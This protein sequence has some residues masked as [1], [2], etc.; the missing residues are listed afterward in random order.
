M[1]F[2]FN[3]VL[4][5]AAIAIS[6][7]V[8]AV[9]YPS[10]PETIATHWGADGTPNGFMPKELG[11]FVLPA[12]ALGVYVLLALLTRISPT[13]FDLESFAETRDAVR[14]FVVVFLSVL[15]IAVDLVAI[16]WAFSML[17]VVGVATGLLFVFLGNVFGKLRKNF[18][19]GIRTPW[20]LASDEVWARTHR[21][22]GRVFVAAG[23]VAIL[24]SFAGHATL[25]ILAAVSTAAVLSLAYSYIIARRL[26]EA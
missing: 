13:G 18:F 22:G 16:G 5:L 4:G 15:G 25:A 21:F 2:T 9:L 7:A 23:L 17:T 11:A 19:I 6:F 20:T 12:T 26:G 24:G 14:T 3:N 1:K 8:T 10:M